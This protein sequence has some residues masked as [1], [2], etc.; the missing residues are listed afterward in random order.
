VNWKGRERKGKY[1]SGVILERESKITKYPSAG[2]TVS[3]LFYK[4]Q[5]G[6][7]THLASYPMVNGGNLSGGKAAGVC[8]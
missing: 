7:G 8:S 3:S 5:T 4:V 2:A 1:Y 6:S